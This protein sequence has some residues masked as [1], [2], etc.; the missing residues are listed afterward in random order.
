MINKK[1]ANMYNLYVGISLHREENSSFTVGISKNLQ[2]RS[3]EKHM[4][5]IWA[6]SYSTRKDALQAEQDVLFWCRCNFDQSFVK[7][8]AWEMPNSK[9]NRGWD[10]FYNEEGGAP[11]DDIKEVLN[12]EEN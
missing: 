5:V 6:C 4:R 3:Y 12:D 10:W 2:R 7:Y 8:G 9:Q 11:L 1:G